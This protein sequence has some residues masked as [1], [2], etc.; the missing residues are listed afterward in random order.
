MQNTLSIRSYSRHKIGH[1][2]PFHQLVLPLRGVINIDIDGFTGKV[3]PSECVVIKKGNVHH[4]TANTEARFVVADM[5]ELPENLLLSNT[6]V[7]SVSQPLLRFLSFVEVQLEYQVNKELERISYLMF[8][9]LMSKQILFKQLNHRIR[10]AVEFIESHITE[11]LPIC[12]LASV[13]CLS[14]TQFKKLFKEQVGLT[15]AQY[16]TKLRMEK[17]QAL[18]IHTDY[19]LQIVAEQVGYTDLTAFS[20]RFSQYFGLSPSKI[21]H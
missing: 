15:A 8:V 13:S 16:V 4:F 17:A 18:L 14:P 9:E 10:E 20:R 19:P 2:H 6:I 1:F 7:F 11:E 5:D 21:S 3:T 12:R